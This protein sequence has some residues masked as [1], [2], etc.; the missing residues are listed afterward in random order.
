VRSFLFFAALLL[1]TPALANTMYKCVDAQ[2][3]VSF[4]DTP[5]PGAMK[6]A[7]QFEIAAPESNEESAAR[8]A[9]EKQRLRAADEAFRVRH[10]QRAR[11]FDRQQALAAQRDAARARAIAAQENKAERRCVH[12]ANGR[13]VCY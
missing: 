9:A 11:E 2:G 6:A 5:C 1:A 3:K 10:A 8:R 7:K 12:K 4:S 13:L